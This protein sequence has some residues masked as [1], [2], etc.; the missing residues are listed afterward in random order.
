MSPLQ[1]QEAQQLSEKLSAMP[2]PARGEALAQ[3]GAALPIGRLA[4]LADQLDAK[5]KP[6][7]LAMKLGADRT[8]AGRVVG[9][10][11]LRGAQ[12]LKDK[13]V[14]KDDTALAGWRAD[15]ASQVRGTLGDERAENDV[16][17]AAYFVR[18]AMDND[19][20]PIAGFNLE[21]STRMAIK[22]VIGEPLERNGVKTIL[23]RGMDENAFDKALSIYTP[24]TLKAAAPSG[25]LYVRGQPVDLQRFSD[26]IGRYGFKRDGRGN[27]LPSSG[28]AFVTTDKEGQL[29]L[30]LPVSPQ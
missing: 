12:A 22:M 2:P 18:A 24:D 3:I 20:T 16:I 15:I 9:D 6:Q 10:L 27:Y 11:V 23:P 25:T 1:P 13:T 28:G 4:A 29:P 30:R 26:S 8:S 17:D 21:A 14:K 5:D 7:A 19:G